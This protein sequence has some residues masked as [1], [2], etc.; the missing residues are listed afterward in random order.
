MVCQGPNCGQVFTAKRKFA[1]YCCRACS[2][3]ASRAG[4]LGEPT[5]APA[6]AGPGRAKR[7]PVKVRSDL[8]K[9]TRSALA[10]VNRVEHWA[11]QAAL[12]LAARIDQGG[13]ETGSALASMVREHA[14]AMD[15]AL[16]A[17]APDDPVAALQDEVAR[18]RERN[19]AA[20]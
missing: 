5:P 15:R 9:W 16:G 20:G 6:G 7:K 19:T 4:Q 11:G 3:R 18:R 1:K 2:V 17:A 13:A 12:V 10:E 14:L 8:E